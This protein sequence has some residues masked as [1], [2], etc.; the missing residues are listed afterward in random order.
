M[1]KNIPTLHQIINFGCLHGYLVEISSFFEMSY[2][3]ENGVSCP[4]RASSVALDDYGCY[5]QPAAPQTSIVP[6][7]RRN[8]LLDETRRPISAP[9][10]GSQ[11]TANKLYPSSLLRLEQEAKENVCMLRSKLIRRDPCY[12]YSM[13][14]WHPTI[15]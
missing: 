13:E 14:Y 11:A 7:G 2:V 5:S 10:H 8:F 6:L 1:Y 4:V 15:R 9:V 3:Y 12:E